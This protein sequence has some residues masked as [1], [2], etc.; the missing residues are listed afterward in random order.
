MIEEKDLTCKKV[1][2]L[3]ENEADKNLEG[4]KKKKKKS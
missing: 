4:T 2:G 3:M 1:E